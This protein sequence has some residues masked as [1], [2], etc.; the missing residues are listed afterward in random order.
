ML[1]YKGWRVLLLLLSGLVSLVIVHTF[2][3]TFDFGKEVARM[4]NSK[5]PPGYAETTPNLPKGLKLLNVGSSDKGSQA[6]RGTAHKISTLTHSSRAQYLAEKF[7]LETVED[8]DILQASPSNTSP[9]PC[10]GDCI[11]LQQH[12]KQWPSS[13]PKAAFYYLTKS[14]R[15]NRLQ[16]SLQLLDGN[17][18]DKYQYPVI[19]FHESNLEASL[20]KIRRF[21]NSTVYFQEI[22]FTMPGFLTNNVTFNIPCL[23]KVSY[24]QMCRFHAKE[25]YEHPIIQGFDYLFRLD[26]DS[27]ITRPIHYDVFGFMRTGD[28]DYGFI[29]SHY[30][31]MSCTKGLWEATE[32]FIN[33]TGIKPYFFHKWKR[34]HIYYNNFE[35][36]RTAIWLSEEYKSYVNYLD[37]LGGM[38]YHR[39]GDAPIKGIAISML[40]PKNKTHLF[41]D[42]GYTHNN[43]NN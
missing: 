32:H 12:L 31:A 20:E 41:K 16:N 34:P 43:F 27:F 6:A 38:F 11:A 15:I 4:F 22:S 23:S 5:W 40:V 21:T 10:V 37:R 39:W 42:I 18:N 24:R 36:S 2:L 33:T 35:I 9:L 13:K 29:W 1:R 26:D 28:T 19:I 17:F 7:G 30:D 8:M 25:I 3:F 14:Q